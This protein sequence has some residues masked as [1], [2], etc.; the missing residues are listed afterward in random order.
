MSEVESADQRHPGMADTCLAARSN[1]KH[2]RILRAPCIRS[3]PEGR[4][5]KT[6]QSKRAKRTLHF[7]DLMKVTGQNRRPTDG[8]GHFLIDG[9]CPA[10]A[11]LYR[12]LGLRCGRSNRRARATGFADSSWRKSPAWRR[13][14][15]RTFRG[16]PKR[17]HFQ[18]TRR[19]AT[20]RSRPS[21]PR[22]ANR[23]QAACSSWSRST[24]PRGCTTTSASSWTA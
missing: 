16:W 18:S 9:L 17:S 15:A 14:S 12:A 1:N 8:I 24:G 5:R 7:A 13:P 20:S 11:D 6:W 10:L 23:Q 22:A 3:E 19:N 2:G 21:R 4:R